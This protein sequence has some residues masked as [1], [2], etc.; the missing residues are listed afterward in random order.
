MIQLH[1]RGIRERRVAE[2]MRA[3]TIQ[4]LENSHIFHTDLG[5]RDV[6]TAFVLILLGT[7]LS[8][9]IV[10]GEKYHKKKKA[11]NP[12]VTLKQ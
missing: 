4:C 2:Y 1:E 6:F 3:T 10:L 11:E 12:P 9:I 7:V 5:L 8:L